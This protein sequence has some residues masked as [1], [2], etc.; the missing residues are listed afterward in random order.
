MILRD[1][2]PHPSRN[3]KISF[4]DYIFIHLGFQPQ[5]VST[6]EFQLGQGLDLRN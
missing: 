6:Y 3:L 2:K 1:T 4:F 5:E